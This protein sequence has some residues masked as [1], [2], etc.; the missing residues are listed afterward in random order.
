MDTPEPTA[1]TL[2][3]GLRSVVD[4]EVGLDVVSLGLIYGLRVEDGE[5]TVR[6]TMTTPACPMSNVLRRQVGAVLQR[7]PG[8]R[9]GV[10]E[11]VWDPPWSPDMV[12][13][14]ARD[15]L[16]GAGRPAMPWWPSARGGADARPGV[17]DRLRALFRRGERR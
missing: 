3:D 7:T 13:P 8:L 12:E 2:S 10:V 4:P 17:W 15:A 11:L 9:R 14:G 16:F 1:L 5:A 6:L